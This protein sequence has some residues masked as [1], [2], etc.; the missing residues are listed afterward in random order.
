M[1]IDSKKEHVHPA[2][3]RVYG[4]RR[5]GP[6]I[7]EHPGLKSNVALNYYACVNEELGPV[8]MKWVTGTTGLRKKY[9]ASVTNL[10]LLSSVAIPGRRVAAACCSGTP[11]AHLLHVV[12]IY[13]E[14]DW[15]FVALAVHHKRCIRVVLA[16]LNCC[17]QQLCWPLCIPVMDAHSPQLLPYNFIVKPAV[18]LLLLCQCF[19][20]H[21]HILV[22]C[23][24]NLDCKVQVGE[25][26]VGWAAMSS[27]AVYLWQPQPICGI[28]CRLHWWHMPAGVAA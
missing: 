16:P 1:W 9:K 27:K 17:C 13:S 26:D 3:L 28:C 6:I 14:L 19:G 18:S 15:P 2:S 21:I 23:A 22:A 20:V 5:D 12:S 11:L 10:L 7:V 25:P 4:D 24:I 8:A